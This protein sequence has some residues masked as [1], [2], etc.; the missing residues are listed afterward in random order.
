MEP[1][2]E[3]KPAGPASDAEVRRLTRD[4]AD[5]IEQREATSEVLRTIG[6][7]V[8]ALQPVFATVVHHAVRLCDAH[9]GQIHQL[10]GDVY[11]LAVA[12]GGTAEYRR[13]LEEHPIPRGTGTLV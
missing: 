11:R 1:A 9:F 4:L 12:L 6:H 3:A 10:D 13:Y 2:A 7:G 8:F 5:A